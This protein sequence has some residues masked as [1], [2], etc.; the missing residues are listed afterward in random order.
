MP[1]TVFIIDDDEGLLAIL[2]IALRDAGYHVEVASN[3]GEALERLQTLSPDL[4]I[5]DV[6]MPYVDGVQFWSQ[7]HERF[8]YEGVPIIVMTALDRKQWFQDLEEQGAV[9]LQKPFDVNQLVDL[10]KTQLDEEPF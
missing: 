7:I 9:I 4:V 10:V 3:G 1:K 6:M 5:S 8:Q 2:E